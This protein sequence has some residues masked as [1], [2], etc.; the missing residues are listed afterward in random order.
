MLNRTVHQVNDALIENSDEMCKY[1]RMSVQFMWGGGVN[2]Y[3]THLSSCLSN[4]DFPLPL[5]DEKSDV[6]P[7]FHMKQLGKV[8]ELMGIPTACH[9]ISWKCKPST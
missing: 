2:L 9:L 1:M 5:F 8:M 7:V 4:Y 3:G 6:N